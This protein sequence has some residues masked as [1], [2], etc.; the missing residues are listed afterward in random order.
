MREWITRRPP[1][2][3]PRRAVIAAAPLEQSACIR[4]DRVCPALSMLLLL[5]MQACWCSPS[6]S[7]QARTSRTGLI[8]RRKR[9]VRHAVR[10]HSLAA[11]CSMLEPSSHSL[12]LQLLPSRCLTHASLSPR[13]TSRHRRDCD[14]HTRRSVASF[15]FRRL[16]PRPTGTTRSKPAGGMISSSKWV[17]RQREYCWR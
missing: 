3:P 2:M 15:T 11:G 12:L 10:A 16:I 4:A 8:L 17:R 14:S 7:S 5:T 6:S 9:C 1:P 13:R